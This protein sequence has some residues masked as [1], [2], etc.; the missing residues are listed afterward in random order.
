MTYTE[1]I[2]GLHVLTDRELVKPRPLIEVIKKVI[3][4]GASVIQLRDKTADDASM[5]ILGREILAL[6]AGKIPLIINDRVSVALA[7]GAA[8]VHVGQNDMA[9]IEV[10]RMIGKN[11]ILGVS[12]S[13]VAQAIKAQKDGADYLGVGPVFSTQTKTDADPPIG[14][15]GL[16]DIRNAVSLPLIAIGGINKKNALQVIQFADGIAVIS[17]V[18]ATDDPL[19]AT[20]ELAIIL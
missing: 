5:I 11:M 18:L 6:T 13:T 4:G 15:G 3:E 16:S 8:G 20:R 7:I 2:G 12:V 10:R 1:K 9:A 14:L 17:A 19:Q